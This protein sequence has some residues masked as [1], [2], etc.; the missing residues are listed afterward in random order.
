M[1]RNQRNEKR[2][3]EPESHRSTTGFNYRYRLDASARSRQ[4][5]DD[6]STWNIKKNKVDRWLG[7]VLSSGDPYAASGE[8]KGDAT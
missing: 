5:N 8:L 2:R 4:R 7:Q 3:I 6:D 1:Q